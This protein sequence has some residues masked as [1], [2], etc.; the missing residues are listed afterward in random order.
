MDNKLNQLLLSQLDSEQ[1]HVDYSAE[2]SFYDFVKTGN[3]E[4][5]KQYSSLHLNETTEGYGV[6]SENPLRNLTYHF[7][8]LAAMLAR[9]C[10]EGGMSRE[11]AYSLSDVYIRQADKCQSVEEIKQLH[12]EMILDYTMR[13]KYI[14]REQLYSRHVT[15]CFSIIDK[16]L[17]RR[18]TVEEIAKEIG[19]NRSHLSRLFKQEVGISL[20]GYILKRKIEAAESMLRLSDKSCAE[21][22]ANFGFASQSHFI[23]VFRRET[24]KTPGKL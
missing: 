2:F 4:Q 16:A 7:V 19:V 11:R 8:I 13:M 20:S 5:L 18:I 9:S 15:K 1:Y 23:Q 3:V 17:N 22:A 12:E 21:V 10:T 24:G 6:L 14:Y